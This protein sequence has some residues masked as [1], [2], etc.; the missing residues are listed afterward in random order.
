MKDCSFI[1]DFITREHQRM[2]NPFEIEF[3]ENNYFK[4]NDKGKT[5]GVFSCEYLDDEFPSFLITIRVNIINQVF[6]QVFS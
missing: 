6:K 2:Q 3:T 1:Y 4:F 5:Y